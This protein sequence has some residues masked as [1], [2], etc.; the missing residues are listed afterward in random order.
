MGRLRVSGSRAGVGVSE[1]G[2]MG[3]EHVGL[4]A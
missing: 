2:R 1:L 4:E 3:R